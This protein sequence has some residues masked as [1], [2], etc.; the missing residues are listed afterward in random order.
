MLQTSNSINFDWYLLFHTYVYDLIVLIISLHF[1]AQI[2]FMLSLIYSLMS[3]FFNWYLIQAYALFFLVFHK[4]REKFM[5]Y[6]SIGFIFN[7]YLT[8]ILYDE[9][10]FVLVYANIFNIGINNIKLVLF[11]IWY[12]YC[13]ISV[14]L[15]KYGFYF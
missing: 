11:S 3:I 5:F 8:P 6:I 10:Y 12:L 9:K 13:K 1:K 15:K 14:F 4:G 2:M 7:W